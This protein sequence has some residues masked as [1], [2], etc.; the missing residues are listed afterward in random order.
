VHQNFSA[1][2]SQFLSSRQKCVWSSMMEDNTLS[3]R[4]PE[5]IASIALAVVLLGDSGL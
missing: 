1:K 4:F 5:S 3:D 2:L